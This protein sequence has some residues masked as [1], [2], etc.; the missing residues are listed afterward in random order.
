MRLIIATLAL[1]A[2][3]FA[4]TCDFTVTPT[5]LGIPAAGV[6]NGQI[7]VTQPSPC[8]FNGWNAATSTPWLH[9]TSG[10]GYNGSSAV[11]FTA[12][13]NTAA[14]QRA[15]TMTV[16]NQTVVITQDG[17]ACNF[18]IAPKSQNF[19]VSGGTGSFA[20]TANCA[21]Q[22]Q[23]NNGNFITLPSASG[24]TDATVNFTVAPNSCVVGR[25]GSITVRTGLPTSPLFTIT[26]DGSPANL[27]LSA[28][29]ATAGPDASDGRFSV[30]TGTGCGWSAT[31]D[32]TWMQIISATGSGNGSVAYHLLANTTAARTGSIH[33]GSLTYTVTQASSAPVIGKVGSA[34]SYG[35]DAISPGEIITVFGANMGP[36]Q[37]APLQVNSGLVTNSLG[38][39]QVLFD[40]AAAPMIY[41]WDKQ[42]SAV[43]PYRIAGK[44]NTQVQVVY[45]GA[46]SNS[47]T[48]PVQS[49]HPGVF[50]QD[51]SG[52]GAG[53]IL[54]EDNSLNTA[55]NPAAPGSVVAIYATGGGTTNPALADGAVTGSDLPYL[56]QQPIVTIG[57]IDAPVKYAGGAPGSV[58]GLTQI[59]AEVPA[60][61][62]AGAVPVVV[63]IGGYASASGVML[64]V[65]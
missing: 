13:P 29:G 27:T 34:A 28:P 21:W 3:L 9:I 46:V 32:V 55:A 64:A 58:A 12:D 61:L 57:G 37:L 62:A 4:Q 19:P 26:Q 52:L 16:A 14:G 33:V 60:G 6:T 54:N 44:A 39:T 43:V 10:R 42:V 50:T 24:N 25:S 65:K 7:T 5:S 36:S 48:M 20:L 31:S 8:L 35:A 2:P 30:N 15:G 18:A 45:R 17:A 51:A 59:N 47:I 38:G 1:A 63:K 41:A 53:A 56:M 40:G 23:S 49:A 22:A 11:T